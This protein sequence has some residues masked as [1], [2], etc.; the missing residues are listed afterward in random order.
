MTVF[1]AALLLSGVLQT[2]D[3]CDCENVVDTA[4]GCVCACHNPVM[5]PEIDADGAISHSHSGGLC[6]TGLIGPGAL[7]PNDIERPPILIS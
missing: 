6:S 7:V 1:V 3:D 4:V 2:G 5:H